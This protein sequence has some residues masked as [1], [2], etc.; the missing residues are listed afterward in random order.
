MQPPDWNLPFELLCNASDYAVGVVLG[1]RKDKKPYLIYYVSRSLNS[2]QINYSTAENELLAVVFTL[3]KFRSYL[4]GPKI[5]VFT[6]H[7]VLKYLLQKK[8]AKPSD[9]SCYSKNSM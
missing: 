8:D 6:A 7:F 4:I 3:D 2:A 1:Q 9:G 5:T